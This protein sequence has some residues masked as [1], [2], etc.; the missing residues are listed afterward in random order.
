MERGHRVGV[1]TTVNGEGDSVARDALREACVSCRVCLG[2]YILVVGA[3]YSKA[4]GSASTNEN[5]TH[6]F[7]LGLH[8]DRVDQIHLDCHHP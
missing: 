4:E 6:S 8:M 2:W 3:A 5:L 1:G 7:S